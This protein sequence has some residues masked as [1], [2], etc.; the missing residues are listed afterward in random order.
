[1][2]L[3]ETLAAI[4]AVLAVYT[5]AIIWAFAWVRSDIRQALWDASRRSASRE[6]AVAKLIRK[7]LAHLDPED[8]EGRE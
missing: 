3:P 8:P 7:I 5:I 4:L 6:H 1:M 2:T